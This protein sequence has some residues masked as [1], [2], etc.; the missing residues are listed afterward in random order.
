[1]PNRLAFRSDTASITKPFTA[2]AAL[3]LVDEGRLELDTPI[4]EIADLT[5]TRDHLPNF[6]AKSPNFPPREGG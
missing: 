2:V 1:M 5:R 3:P 4:T 6:A